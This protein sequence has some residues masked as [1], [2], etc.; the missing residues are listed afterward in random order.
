MSTEIRK[1]RE[2]AQAKL[3]SDANLILAKCRILKAKLRNKAETGTI[4]SV[5]KA[6]RSTESSRN[7][8]GDEKI[9]KGIVE[10]DELSATE[11][12]EGIEGIALRITQQVLGKKGFSMEI[13][14]RSASN[15]I[16]IK[17]WDRIVL[18]G[19]RIGRNFMN[20]RESR[21]SVITLRVMEL[22]HAVLVWPN[23][24]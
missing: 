19:K 16:Y 22:L 4:Q 18:G 23:R 11:V 15:Q 10:V 24:C 8:N 3:A 12:V 9:P 1:H 21:K 20:V 7:D 5:I 13:P 6:S 14:S 2:H 17:K